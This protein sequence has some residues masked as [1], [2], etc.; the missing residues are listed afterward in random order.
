MLFKGS[1][2]YYPGIRSVVPL[3]VYVCGGGLLVPVGLLENRRYL[4]QLLNLSVSTEAATTP[5]R[6]PMLL[7]QFSCSKI[8]SS[9]RNYAVDSDPDTSLD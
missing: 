6:A 9:C 8:W 1:P 2:C 5:A 4:E 3:Q 7:I